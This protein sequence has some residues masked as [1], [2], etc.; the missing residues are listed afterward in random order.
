[1]HVICTYQPVSRNVSVQIALGNNWD[2]I[3]VLCSVSSDSE[4]KC[5]VINRCKLLVKSVS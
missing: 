5:S 4:C 3:C 1:M 2:I